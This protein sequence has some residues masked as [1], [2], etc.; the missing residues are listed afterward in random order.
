MVVSITISAILMG[1]IAMI[2][3]A[4]VQ[5]YLEQSRRNEL[6]DS[7]E[8]IGRMLENDLA[9]ALPNS[10][11]ISDFGNT[12]VMQILEVTDI[13]YYQQQPSSPTPAQAAAGLDFISTDTEFDAYGSFS[14][15]E[16]LVVIN[17][18]DSAAYGNGGVMVTLPTQ[19]ATA[20]GRHR[21][22][23]LTPFQFTGGT[24]STNRMFAIKDSAL[25]YVCNLTTGRLTR[26]I[27]H[28]RNSAI[29]VNESAPQLNSAGARSS[30]VAAGVTACVFGCS[31]LIGN[32]C[33]TTLTFT[34]TVS[35]GVTPEVDRI[36]VM[37][38]FG[39]ENTT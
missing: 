36:H 32:T 19:N 22:G 30:V 39:V 1:T 24:S 10:V 16:S 35:R 13:L 7:S 34:A 9:R 5:T 12:K 14:S 27:D 28:A 37:R 15:D 2:M 3:G 26:F 4:P 25:T 20:F 38:Q 18:T 31:A 6:I 8:R 33:F 29:P 11:R 17:N 21:I 23:P